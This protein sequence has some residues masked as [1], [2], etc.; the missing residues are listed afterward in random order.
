MTC[1]C[2]SGQVYV[3]VTMFLK[4]VMH[5]LVKRVTSRISKA[6]VGVYLAVRCFVLRK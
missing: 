1:T 6:D 3:M 4:Y 2:L 5:H